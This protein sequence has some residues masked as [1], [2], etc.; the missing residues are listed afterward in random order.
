MYESSN[1]FLSSP[2]LGIFGT[3]HFSSDQCKVVSHHDFSLV[4]LMVN[5]AEGLSCA[6]FPSL[7]PLWWSICLNL[8]P[9]LKMDCFCTIKSWEFFTYSGYKSFIDR[10]GFMKM[11][12][13]QSQW[14][15]CLKGSQTSFNV[16]LSWS[17]IC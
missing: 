14:V 9:I 15:L 5:D 10:D 12:P 13:V 1:S 4:S 7:Y 6:Y 11:W 2:V 3:F 8:L 16:L 17:W